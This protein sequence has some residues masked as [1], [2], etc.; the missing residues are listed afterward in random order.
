M[1]TQ[2]QQH[3]IDLYADLMEEVKI[4]LSCIEIAVSGKLFLPSKIVEEICY[5]QLRMLCELIAL[6]CL[7]AHGDIAKSKSLQKAWAADKS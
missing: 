6:G 2:S 1:V 4:R 3:A 5:L 7:T